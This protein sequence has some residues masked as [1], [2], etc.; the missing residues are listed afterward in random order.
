MTGSGEWHSYVAHGL[1]LK[2][3]FP[4]PGMRSAAPPE[5]LPTLSVELETS[6]AMDA[7]W[8]G[9]LYPSPW[10]GRLGDGE[11]LTIEWGV[12]GDLRFAYGERARF[13]LDPAGR[14]LGCSPRDRNGL[15]WQR[16]LLSRILPNVSVAHGR[17]ALHACALE[18]P[19]GVVAVA[20]PSGTGKS[21]LARA[22]MRKGWSLFADDVLT[23]SRDNGS[24]RAHA[25]TPHMNLAADGKETGGLGVVLAELSGERWIAA[26]GASTSSRAVSAVAILERGP[27]RSLAARPLRRS[28]ILLTPYMLGLPD[29]E[30]RDAS[31][32]ALY[33]DLVESACLIELT[34]GP[35]DKPED[36]ADALRGELDSTA[37]TVAEG[38]A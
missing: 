18:A 34:G 32:F 33:S 25:G 28:P 35:E 15:D 9:S 10:R 23:L 16:V 4:L 26:E 17:E 5:P 27:G 22:L 8:S 12:E 14:R 24:V 20:A 37:A 3:T 29:E 1:S 36:L 31:R 7:A 19:F 21:T 38:A 11:K 13:R 2:S 6:E 30:A